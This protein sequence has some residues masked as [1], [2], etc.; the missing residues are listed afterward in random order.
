MFTS[1]VF[2]ESKVVFFDMKFIL[3]N[4]KAGKKAQEYLKKHITAIKKNF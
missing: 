4:S 2:A 3:N 1:Q